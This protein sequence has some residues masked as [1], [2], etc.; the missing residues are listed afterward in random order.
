M[1]H[2]PE[3]TEHFEF[4]LGK[5]P[6]LRC[7]NGEGT[8]TCNKCECC[9]IRVLLLETQEWFPRAGEH[10]KRRFVLGLVRRFQSVNLLQYVIMILKPLIGK[11]FTYARSRTNPGVIGDKADMGC[12]RALRNAAID[13]EIGKIWDWFKNAQYWSKA[14]YVL[15]LLQFCDGNLLHTVG[16]Q[17]RTM[18]AAELRAAKGFNDDGKSNHKVR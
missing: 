14:N 16:T 12:D 7:I 9:R 15:G 1:K 11:D 2:P 5:A 18:L 13:E 17:A 3:N 4:N 8:T 10:T 6:D